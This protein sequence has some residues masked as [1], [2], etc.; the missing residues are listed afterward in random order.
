MELVT[1]IR[2]HESK[3][4]QKLMH[5]GIS[6]DVCDDRS[7][8][9]AVHLA[10]SLCNLS[11]VQLL[12]HSGAN[13]ELP[14]RRGN[15]AIHVAV[16]SGSLAITRLLL[17][18]GANVNSQNERDIT[19][20]LLA[21]AVGNE[22]LVQILIDYNADV[23]LTNR[24][25]K[26]AVMIGAVNGFVTIVQQ[27]LDCRANLTLL[28]HNMK[29][30][31]H[32]AVLSGNIEVYDM[33]QENIVVQERNYSETLLAAAQRGYSTI[34]SKLVDNMPCDK[35]FTNELRQS[36]LHIAVQG[37]HKR[38][39][40]VLLQKGVTVDR[41]DHG[42][43]GANTA[44]IYA[45]KNNLCSILRLL[46]AAG[47]DLDKHNVEQKTA[48]YYAAERGHTQATAI[49]LQAFR[50]QSLGNLTITGHE[51]WHYQSALQ[52]VMHSALEAA[53]I[54]GHLKIVNMLLRAGMIRKLKSALLYAARKG[55]HRIIRCIMKFV[56]SENVTESTHSHFPSQANWIKAMALAVTNGHL[57]V[58][59]LFVQRGF[60]KFVGYDFVKSPILHSKTAVHLA[61]GG[62]YIKIVKLLLRNHAA[63]ESIDEF[64]NTPFLYAVEMNRN[65]VAVHFLTGLSRGVPLLQSVNVCHKNNAALYLA[66][67]NGNAVLLDH[68][69][70]AGCGVDT[71]C[72]WEVT[73]GFLP[74][75]EHRLSGFY[76]VMVTVIKRNFPATVSLLNHSCSLTVSSIVDR[77]VLT[78]LQSATK[79]DDPLMFACLLWSG[80]LTLTQAV[81][82]I[83]NL[84]LAN[85]IALTEQICDWL[86][87]ALS[88]P[89]KLQELC[90]MVIRQNIS[91][92]MQNKIQTLLL[93]KRLQMYLLLDDF[94]QSELAYCDKKFAQS[95]FH[96]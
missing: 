44:L 54:N 13:I 51:V 17:E 3:T 31:L 23:N 30:V 10:I 40:A 57:R 58:V 9:P 96:T 67:H 93:P 64:D 25:Q 16:T 15:R 21:A 90:R 88:T 87:Q 6:A 73:A 55:A 56:C 38:T 47:A 86:K 66:A 29:D 27:L 78:P 79:F 7:G 33:I 95:F 68:L 59:K 4:I 77:V 37:R 74:S 81:E 48:I 50:E 43:L 19:P 22:A 62:G 20:L 70:S 5:S 8:Q 42:I 60:G 36:A 52:V 75:I 80:N 12:I 34:I 32:Y 2:N 18:V 53:V 35:N 72:S 94:I 84:R 26:S 28:D 76:P 85:I 11:S 65:C 49:L 41:R 89:I 71:Q 91:G 45:A 83:H 1:A 46:L 39:T 14:D 24:E 63:P 82:Q 61:A 92:Q 69:V